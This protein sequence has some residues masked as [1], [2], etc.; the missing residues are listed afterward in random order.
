MFSA[1]AENHGSMNDKID[2]FIAMAPIVNMFCA[3][4][5]KNKPLT[6]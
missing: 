1:L 2:M 3:D 6:R 4:E 5:G